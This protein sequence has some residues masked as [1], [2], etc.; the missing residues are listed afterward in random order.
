MFFVLK[1]LISYQISAVERYSCLFRCAHVRHFD[2]LA[3]LPLALV[4]VLIIICVVIST[5]AC[6]AACCTHTLGCDYWPPRF[7]VSVSQRCRITRFD[8]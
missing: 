5:P 7:W 8:V 6:R 1:L 3:D 4:W 2:I